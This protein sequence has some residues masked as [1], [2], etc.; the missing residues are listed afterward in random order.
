MT[1]SAKCAACKVDAH[2]LAPALVFVGGLA[3]ALQ[4][5]SAVRHELCAKHAKVLSGARK[6]LKGRRRSR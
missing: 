2:T 3:V 4:Y 5:G 6:V 1:A